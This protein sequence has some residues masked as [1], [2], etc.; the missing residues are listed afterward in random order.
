MFAENKK[1]R[2]AAGRCVFWGLPLLLLITGCTGIGSA[3]I[4][5]HAVAC[6]LLADA[7]GIL[8]A[9]FITYFFFG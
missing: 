4:G 7:A 3:R 2:A 5:R 1:I 8:T 9:I 6:G